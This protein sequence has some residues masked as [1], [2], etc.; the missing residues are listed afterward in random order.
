MGCDVTLVSIQYVSLGRKVPVSNPLRLS[1]SIVITK[2]VI[3]LL[4]HIASGL[5]AFILPSISLSALTAVTSS[6]ILQIDQSLG[7]TP[8]LDISGATSISR[9]KSNG[10]FYSITGTLGNQELVEA[11]QFSTQEITVI[12]PS[13]VYLRC[14]THGPNGL[15][16]SDSLSKNVGI[17]NTETGQWMH[18]ALL[19]FL[20]SATVIAQDL[21]GVIHY[22]NGDGDLHVNNG[23]E[24]PV[25]LKPEFKFHARSLGMCGDFDDD[26]NSIVSGVFQ[27]EG[28]INACTLSSKMLT[29]NTWNARKVLMD[30]TSDTLGF[31]PSVTTSSSPSNAPTKTYSKKPC[32][33]PSISPSDHPSNSP[34]MN[35]TKY[36]TTSPSSNPTKKPSVA[37]SFFPS[38]HTSKSPTAIPKKHLQINQLLH[39]PRIHRSLLHFQ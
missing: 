23:F 1:T 19:P 3:I 6:D 7:V 15:Y 4:K 22:V 34:S 38:S 17:L 18:I 35:P 11:C 32:V 13:E 14:L 16:A 2:L 30:V 33:V 26:D 12:N 9:D 21:L 39:R 28:G 27:T 37:H 10:K 5:V 8:I 24:T 25:R 36:P 20:Y 29:R 31:C